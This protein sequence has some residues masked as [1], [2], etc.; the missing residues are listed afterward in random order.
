MQ[1]K[2][3][4]A[5][6]FLKTESCEKSIPLSSPAIQYSN[7]LLEKEIKYIEHLLAG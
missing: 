3:V 6:A 7:G 2:G 1:T 5:G 4:I